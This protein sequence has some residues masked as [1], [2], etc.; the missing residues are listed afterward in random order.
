MKNPARRKFIVDSAVAS[1]GLAIGWH[2]PSAFAAEKAAGTEVNAWVVIKPDN[3]TVIRVARSEM[4]QGTITGLAQL[5]AEELECD[6]SKVSVEQVTA[7]QN[8][9]RKRVWGEMSTGGSR[10]I[11]TSHDYVRRGGAAARLMLVQAAAEA[12]RVPASQLTTANGVIMHGPSKRIT[13]YGK[14]AA[15]AAKLAPPDSKSIR[16]KDPRQWRVAGQPLKRLDTAPKLNGSKIYSIDFKLPGMLLAA[17]KQCPVFTG[18]LASYDDS[19]VRGM[20]GVKRVLKVNDSTVAVVADTW[21]HAKSAL[22]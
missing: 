11:R 18:T 7:G 12:W 2:L 21:W 8:L 1:G 20:P 17:V 5:V 9:A 16:L 22:E 3:S 10:G 15:Q 19:K 14:M 6:W 13:T 4:G